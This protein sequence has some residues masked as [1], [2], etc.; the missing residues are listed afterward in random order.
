MSFEAECAVE[1]VGSRFCRSWHVFMKRFSVLWR[2]NSEEW[3]T[4]TKI[5]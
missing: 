2:S 5:C 3:I 4:F 1:V